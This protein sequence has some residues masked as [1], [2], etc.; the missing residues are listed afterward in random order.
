MGPFNSFIKA[1]RGG[2]G[3]AVSAAGTAL[4]APSKA[5]GLKTP[6]F[7]ISERIAGKK[8]TYTITL[9]SGTKTLATGY[10]YNDAYKQA[11]DYWSP[12]NDPN[13]K[14]TRY[15][16]TADGGG[17]D[18]TTPVDGGGGARY[19][20]DYAALTSGRNDL[21]NK[22][23]A[24][25]SLYG[26]IYGD[27]QNLT[28]T[29]RSQLEADYGQQYNDAQKAYTTGLDKISNVMSSRGITDSSYN[30][31]A[32][33]TAKDAYNTDLANLDKSKQ[34]DL[35]KI[36]QFYQSTFGGLQQG[37]Q[38]L[39]GINPDAYSTTADIQAAQGQLGQVEQGLNQQRWNLTPESQAV[40]QL[41]AIAPA[42]STTSDQ[43]T[44]QL[45]T[46]VTSSA[47]RFAKEQI[48]QGII[49]R[50]SLQD[51]NA[52]AYWTDYFQRLLAGA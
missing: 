3:K 47:P 24:L 7:G 49:K 19:G 17:S 31:E 2:A 34:A 26:S 37:Q 8:N 29:K 35:T 16:G 33:G 20:G 48:A 50:A 32:Q 10:D 36:A 5:L 43:L 15:S 23:A 14:I 28:N 4:N 27:L 6:D 12:T 52:E 40:Q 41:N 38:Q 13:I 51:P 25:N 11:M 42:K 45:Q 9:P 1:V 39:A 18:Q 22:I 46:L 30:A 44:N 21:R